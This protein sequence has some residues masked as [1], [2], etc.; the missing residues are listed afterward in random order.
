MWNRATV[1]ALALG[2]ALA[3]AQDSPPSR[4]D[5][6]AALGAAKVAGGALCLAVSAGKCAKWQRAAAGGALLQE[7]EI[8]ALGRRT[9]AWREWYA[10]GVPRLVGTLLS[11]RPHGQITLYREDGIVLS[12][13]WYDEQG[14]LH[15]TCAYLQDDGMMLTQEWVHGEQVGV[16]P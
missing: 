13:E 1:L 2:P 4:P 14:L 16:T 6:P 7:V 9:G 10:S 12:V 15:G 11:G 8:D 3:V 5:V